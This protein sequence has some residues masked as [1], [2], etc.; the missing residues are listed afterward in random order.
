MSIG[1]QI[2]I[3]FLCSL[4]MTLTGFVVRALVAGTPDPAEWS[5]FSAE[6]R[7]IYQFITLGGAVFGTYAGYILMR[8]YAR[9][10]AKGTRGL[11]V[12]RYLVGI[13]GLLL[14]YFGLDAAFAALAPD[15]ST[16]GYIL[17]YLRYGAATFWAT[18]L[19][20]WV[21]LKTKLAAAE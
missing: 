17:R 3:G 12:A 20:P 14:L 13:L 2:G 11:R 1:A 10:S 16:L 5:S 19:A 18:F 6:A 9:F 21:F 15:D 4:L 8:K 7:N